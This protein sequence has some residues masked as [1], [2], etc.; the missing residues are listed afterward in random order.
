[1]TPAVDARDL[2]RVHS[3]SEG[4]AAALQGLTLSV[5]EREI[6][7]VLGPS[8]AGKTSFLRI[9]A[10]LD[11]PSAGTVRVFGRDLR[12]LG[13]RGRARYRAETIGYLDQHY[14]RA[15]APELTAREL[16][17][18]KL[19]AEGVGR[20]EREARAEELLT[21]VGLAAKAGSRPPQLSGGEQQR[22]ALCTA[23]AHR[24]RLLLADEPTGELDDGS[25]RLVYAAIA[26]LAGAESC[27]AVIVS[28]DPVSTAIADRFVHIRDGR[29]SEETLRG[30]AGDSLIVVGRG[31]WLRLPQEFLDRAGIG[32]RAAAS[33]EDDRIVVVAAGADGRP[34]AEEAATPQRVGVGE[35]VALLRG[36]HKSFGRGPAA[37]HVFSALDASFE[38]GRMTVVTG[39][40][41]S[42]KT[43]LLH[44]LA[45]LDL[46][47]AGEIEV[48]GA[49]VHALDRAGRAELR[50]RYIAL[51]AQQPGL[52]P[53][54][55]ARENAD[56]AE[57]IRGRAGP[58]ARD[59]LGVVGLSERAS[60]R[61]SRLSAGEQVR[62][63]VARA[64]VA[65]PRLLLVDEPT[66]RLD[67]ANALTLAALL[68]RLARE[69][70]AAVVCATHDPVVIEQAAGELALAGAQAT[71]RLGAASVE[72]K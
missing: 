59:A 60:Q 47:D 17:G 49:P 10:G 64:L 48:C 35:T 14:A 25:A 68:S 38:S 40:S 5:P 63:A 8:G 20:A 30:E 23:V 15:L 71:R 21:R 67:Q 58:D 55:S 22:V 31:G 41:G 45:G 52:V 12:S 44:L 11:V 39:P 57:E 43:T 46:P 27:T 3:T 13:V 28:H 16:V 4:D 51:V 19:R 7:T 36:V 9:L 62:V 6:L 1:M 24:P 70:G 61:V 56:L 37:A 72:A 53:F 66:A 42:G 2:F 69:T 50:R 32:T 29:V 65:E 34:A 26:E 54:L 33:L 18:L